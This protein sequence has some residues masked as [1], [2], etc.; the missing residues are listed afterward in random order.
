MAGLK[1]TKKKEPNT[2]PNTVLIIFVVFLFLVTIGLG[3]WVYYEHDAQKVLRDS[4]YDMKKA[5]EAE[6]TAGAFHSMMAAQLR[7]AI[8]E[9]LQE[10]EKGRVD[11]DLPELMKDNYGK[12]SG[13]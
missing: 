3:T 12:F 1:K 10:D 9:K 7:V 11:I 13:E 6:K 5:L 2:N 8:G 4:T